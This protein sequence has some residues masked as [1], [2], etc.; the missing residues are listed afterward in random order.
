MKGEIYQLGS[1]IT[2]SQS[3]HTADDGT[4]NNPGTGFGRRR[5]RFSEAQLADASQVWADLMRGHL[6]PVLMDEAFH[7]GN[8][9]FA[10]NALSRRYPAV[11]NESISVQDFSIL[12]DQILDRQ[13]QDMWPAYQPT[14][15]AVARIN[16]NIKDFR[17]VRR[18]Q[19]DGMQDVYGQ[20]HEFETHDRR[21]PLLASTDYFVSKYAAGFARSWEA[22]VNDDMGF[23]QD[24]P[25]RLV[26]GGINS[27]EKYV[28]GLYV[29]AGTSGGPNAT[30][31]TSGHGNIIISA[32]VT[33]PLF[34]LAAL[35]AAVA[36]MAAF[37]DAENLP[38][39]ID[40]VTVVF[41]NYLDYIAAQNVKRALFANI[42]EAGGTT[43]QQLRTPAWVADQFTP[44]FNPWI[45][46][47]DTTAASAHARQWYI[48]ANPAKGRPAI[49]LGFLRGF[50]TPQLY[51]K[52]PN[53]I[54]VSGGAV[55][56]MGDFDTM[57]SEYKSMIVYG[58]VTMEYR[59]T[60]SSNGS[61]S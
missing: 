61:L 44:V 45:N 48:F 32:G 15:Q 4:L 58:G 20:V 24:L 14:Y 7:P 46:I 16:P 53:T 25:T 40:G 41:A 5:N 42:T 31:Y 54:S 47:L 3:F 49:E 17:S 37:K 27:V 33:N 39:T 6:S 12:T 57:S 9:Q 30:T 50:S 35:E 8:D 43:N 51:R 36:Q 19:I 1:G 26:R 59:A 21:A 52:M 23:F 56:N 11:F 2:E 55:D 60:M 18:Y 22:M 34:S 38:I 28:T 10:F 13:I 29:T